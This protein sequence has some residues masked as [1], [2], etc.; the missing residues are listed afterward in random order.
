MS[1]E[2]NFSISATCDFC[3]KNQ[4]HCSIHSEITKK[5]RRN[6]T[7][8]NNTIMPRKRY[9]RFAKNYGMEKMCI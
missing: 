4:K 8:R 9:H 6:K 7:R 3:V 1:H 5:H 2:N